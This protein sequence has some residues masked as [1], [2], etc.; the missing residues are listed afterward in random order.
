[1]KL[2]EKVITAERLAHLTWAAS[3]LSEGGYVLIRHS[4]EKD[5][6]FSEWRVNVR[7]GEMEHTSTSQTQ[8]LARNRPDTFG[9]LVLAMDR[10][11]QWLRGALAQE[12]SL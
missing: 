7:L 3:A 5:G 9:A 8:G 2:T 10:A 4:R 1:M 12:K 6:R 11:V